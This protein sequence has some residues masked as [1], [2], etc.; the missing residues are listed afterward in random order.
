[1][2]DRDKII[3]LFHELMGIELRRKSCLPVHKTAR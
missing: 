1:M 2:M 3:E